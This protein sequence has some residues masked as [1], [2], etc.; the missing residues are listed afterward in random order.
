M[1]KKKFELFG[2][3]IGIGL[4]I[5]LVV[6]FLTSQ[7][8]MPLFFGRTKSIEVPN[9]ISM[10]LTKAKSILTDKKLHTIVSDSSWSDA[11]ARGY[12]LSQKPEF[13]NVIKPDGTVY[14]EI[15]RGSKFVKV[16][17]VVGKDVQSAW[18]ILKE[19]N[20]RFVVA[21]SVYSDLYPTDIV[22]QTSPGAGNKAEKNSKVQ[23]Y[24]S[25]GSSSVYNFQEEESPV[26][27]FNF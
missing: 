14:L 13:G 12:V 2:L 8:V 7:L 24:I 5:I 21:D 3:Y 20:L 1:R 9:V 25:K 15:S 10:D 26:S 19:K 4:G 17:D 22:V 11:M 18:I 16:P 27:D 6:A 23:L